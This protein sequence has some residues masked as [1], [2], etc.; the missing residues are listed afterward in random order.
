MLTRSR[1]AHFLMNLSKV[2]FFPTPHRF[3][4][5]VVRRKVQYSLL[6]PYFQVKGNFFGFAWTWCALCEPSS[7]RPELCMAVSSAARSPAKLMAA[8][9]LLA[10]LCPVDLGDSMS[11]LL[12]CVV[13]QCA[14]EISRSFL[15]YLLQRA[16]HVFT[17][18]V[19]IPSWVLCC[20]ET[21]FAV[22]ILGVAWKSWWQ[23]L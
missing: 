3:F 4:F 16:W 9:F 14:G 8:E 15:S 5:L 2:V 7:R 21:R 19:N 10:C 12:L 17:N 1:D 6:L 23:C 13:L 22:K 11:L 18:N 20:P